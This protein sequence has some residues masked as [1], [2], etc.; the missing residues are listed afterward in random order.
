[1]STCARVSRDDTEPRAAVRDDP[2]R[3][4]ATIPASPFDVKRAAREWVYFP[5]ICALPQPVVVVRLRLSE[6]TAWST[7]KTW[8]TAGGTMAGMPTAAAT[9]ATATPQK[10]ATLGGD[11]RVVRRCFFCRK[12]KKRFLA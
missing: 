3:G 8:A 4:R 5:P 2:D 6:A 1:M 11:V 7:T 10:R 12:V 9:T